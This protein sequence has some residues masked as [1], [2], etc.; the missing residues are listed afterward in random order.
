M[1][2][3]THNVFLVSIEPTGKLLFLGDKGPEK[4]N[5]KFE[6]Y[7]ESSG[8]IV[9]RALTFHQCGLE[10]MS[11]SHLANYSYILLSLGV[12]LKCQL[13]NLFEELS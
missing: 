11:A 4:N 10:S 7:Y 2:L 1:K 3:V 12:T 9:V 13:C 6:Q 5:N 8:G